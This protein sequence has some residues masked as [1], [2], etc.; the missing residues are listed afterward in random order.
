MQMV[1][2]KSRFSTNIFSITAGSN[3]PQHLDGMRTIVLTV[4][5]LYTNAALP[6]ISGDF[7]YNT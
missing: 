1:Y 6:R 7:V 5:M 4:L 2:K 3:M